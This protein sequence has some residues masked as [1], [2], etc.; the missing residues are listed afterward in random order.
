MCVRVS[1]VFGCVC[2]CV[3]VCLCVCVRCVCVCVCVC[4]FVSVLMA[5]DKSLLA[6]LTFLPY[7]PVTRTD[8]AALQ[9]RLDAITIID[10]D[11]Q[12]L[13][14]LPHHQ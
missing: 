9:E 12:A 3:C 14:C 1:V 7:V 10:S 8:P 2:V 6:P 4:V 11:V 13:L 5:Q